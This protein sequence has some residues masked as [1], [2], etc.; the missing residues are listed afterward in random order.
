[1]TG[2]R[3]PSSVNTWVIPI[4]LPMIAATASLRS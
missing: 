3:V 1:V 2:T 4:F